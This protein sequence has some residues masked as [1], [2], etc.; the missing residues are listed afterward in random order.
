M[1]ANHYDGSICRSLIKVNCINF[2][3]ISIVSDTSLEIKT[4]RVTKSSIFGFFGGEE[5][6]IYNK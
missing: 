6:T 3:S 4:Y 2:I 5:N 1:E